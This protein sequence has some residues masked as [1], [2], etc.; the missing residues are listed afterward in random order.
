MLKSATCI[1]ASL[2][3]LA[4]CQKQA[5][6]T[7]AGANGNA[8]SSAVSAAGQ[9][10]PSA[11]PREAI[12]QYIADLIADGSLDRD[13]AGWRT[14]V[15]QPPTVA[16][17]PDVEYF[18][19]L[20]TNHGPIKIKLRP[21]WAPKHIASTI[22]L[23]DMGFYD[24]LSFHRV[25]PGFMAQGGDPVGDGTGGP[26]FRMTAEIHP[27]AKHDRRGSVATARTP[28]PNS[29]GSQFYITFGPTPSLDGGYTVFGSVVEGDETLAALEQRGSRSGRTATPLV[30]EKAVILGVSDPGSPASSPAMPAADD[31]AAVEQAAADMITSID[32]AADS[33]AQGASEIADQ[34]ADGLADLTDD[35]AEASEEVAQDVADAAA[36]LISE[37]E[38]PAEEA[39]EAADAAEMEVD[40]DAAE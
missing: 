29:D 17:P 3:L 2:F 23:T 9:G 34:A 7:D 36:D 10:D 18:W 20:T 12:A 30:I 39:V 4:G 1:I 38:E 15:P 19:M 21:D 14:R 31:A 6:P 35:A 33:T 28:A 8:A 24:G 32:D 16:F 26:A 27:K 40:M 25:I 22:Y 11:K 13:T 5:P 37:T